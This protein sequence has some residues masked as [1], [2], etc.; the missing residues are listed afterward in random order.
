MR[1]EQQC[2]EPLRLSAHLALILLMAI[3]FW[4]GILLLAHAV[5]SG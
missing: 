5:F 3:L 2:P 4:C 1:I